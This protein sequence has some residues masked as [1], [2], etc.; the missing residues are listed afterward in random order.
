VRELEIKIDPVYENGSEVLRKPW[1][2]RVDYCPLRAKAFSSWVNLANESDAQVSYS[3]ERNRFYE[4][5]PRSQGKR[6]RVRRAA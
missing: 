5:L 3:Y 6:R 2:Q 1:T 4:F